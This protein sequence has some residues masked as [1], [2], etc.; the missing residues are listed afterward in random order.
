MP[1][2]FPTTGLTANQTTYTFSGN[3]WIWNG[4]AWDTVVNPESVG[5]TGYV[6]SVNGLTGVVTGVAVTGA[7]TFTGL[8]TL[9]GGI[10]TDNLYVSN[11]ATFAGNLKV[12]GNL[13]VSGGVTSTFSETVLIEDNFITLNSN[14]IT[15]TPTENAG[16]SISRG[17]SAQTH[18]RWNE[19][20]KRWQYTNNGTDY[21]NL[22]S[23]SP[24]VNP[25]PIRDKQTAFVNPLTTLASENNQ[26][27]VTINV[28]FNSALRPQ[29]NGLLTDEEDLIGGDRWFCNGNGKIF[30]WV[31]FLSVDEALTGAWVEL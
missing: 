27:A 18:L 1:L 20:S 21:Y 16:I 24:I 31:E 14:V 2:N 6:T 4:Y 11:G 9:N 17:A 29:Y 19:T 22:I 13:T 12:N 8:Q 23:S 25:I 3:T 26:D 10:T 5:I 15:G 28:Y 7:N 30:T